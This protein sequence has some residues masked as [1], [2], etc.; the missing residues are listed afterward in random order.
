MDATKFWSKAHRTGDFSISPRTTSFFPLSSL[1]PLIRSTRPRRLPPPP[2]RASVADGR[3]L[4]FPALPV[5]LLV[6]PMLLLRAATP[7]LPAAPLPRP[8]G[9]WSCSPPIG[10]PSAWTV[11]AAR[12][13]LATGRRL[14]LELPSRT[15]GSQ[16]A[17]S[18]SPP[19][20]AV[21]PRSSSGL[22]RL[23][24]IKIWCLLPLCL[25]LLSSPGAARQEDPR[26]PYELGRRSSIDGATWWEK[27]PARW[28][29]GR[30]REGEREDNGE[31]GVGGGF[32]FFYWRVRGRQNLKP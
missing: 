30:L 7:S 11:A 18:R 20:L 17:A 2:P 28:R 22:G 26:R 5:A 6:L 16:A 27:R 29:G 32:V 24:L 25:D 12:C 13:S 3:R 9:T 21:D 10:A 1:P 31:D 23:K 15:H 19:T 4:P 14:R 8:M